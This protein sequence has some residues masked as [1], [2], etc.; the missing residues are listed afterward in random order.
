MT[1]VSIED[2][3]S[4]RVRLKFGNEGQITA[5]KLYEKMV[6]EAAKRCETCDGEGTVTCDTCN[7]TG[8]K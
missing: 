8:E 7:G 3:L 6:E 5:I 1:P 2:L 4:S